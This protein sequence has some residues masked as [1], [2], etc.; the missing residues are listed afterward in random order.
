VVTEDAAFD[1]FVHAQQRTLLRAAW[2]MCG[3]WNS[4]EDLVQQSLLEI[5]RRWS[6]V[7]QTTNPTGYA[8]R[9]LVTSHLRTVRRRSTSE[10][11]TPSFEG[12][13]PRGAAIDDGIALHRTVQDALRRLPPRQRAVLVCR[14]F[15]DQT[16][17]S[18]AVILGCRRGTV[19]SASAKALENLRRDPTF[20][21][22][23]DLGETNAH[24]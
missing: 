3:D 1:A 21:T 20:A 18:T 22:W 10:V 2:L 17:E 9:V 13:P 24:R 16:E 6:R 14:Y 12:S 4:A 7:A 11:P 15:L 8:Y 5:W 23:H 19:K